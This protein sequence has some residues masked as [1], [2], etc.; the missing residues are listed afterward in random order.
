M[1]RSL[2]HLEQYSV[3]PD[4][5]S[6]PSPPSTAGSHLTWGAFPALCG[7]HAT[8]LERWVISEIPRNIQVD[9]WL[10]MCFHFW[11][12]SLDPLPNHSFLLSALEV[13]SDYHISGLFEIEF[14]NRE[15]EFVFFD[16][17]SH[18]INIEQMLLLV[19]ISPGILKCYSEPLPLCIKF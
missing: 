2:F 11:V 1:P 9:P 14:I 3:D 8:K 17:A 15:V 16:R 10:D 4:K 13:T 5:V 6:R 7:S 18:G 12:F 19:I